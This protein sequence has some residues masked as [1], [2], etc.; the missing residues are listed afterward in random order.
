MTIGQDIIKTLWGSDTADFRLRNQFVGGVLD[1][2]KLSACAFVK[3]DAKGECTKWERYWNRRK[4]KVVVVLGA[5]G[6]LYHLALLKYLDL[7]V[8][9]YIGAA[10]VQGWYYTSE[11]ATKTE[12][13]IQAELESCLRVPVVKDAATAFAATI[14]NLGF[15]NIE[16]TAEEDDAFLLCCLTNHFREKQPALARFPCGILVRHSADI[17]N[18]RPLKDMPLHCGRLGLLP[19]CARMIKQLLEREKE[20]PANIWCNVGSVLSDNLRNPQ[21]ALLCFYEAIRIDPRLLQP[22]KN[23][24]ITGKR[25][26]HKCF[27]NRDFATAASCA[28]EVVSVGDLTTKDHGFFSYRGLALEKLNRPEDARKAY[29]AALK[30]DPDCAISQRGL[31]R[32]KAGND[33]HGAAQQIQLLIESGAYLDYAPESDYPWN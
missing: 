22:R 1:V 27:V 17:K 30:I 33:L 32:L 21:A 14:R 13:A 29:E 18:P 5:D 2:A 3:T 4:N 20:L 12:N 25:L 24:W 9:D 26:M 23:V 16:R 11:C 31:Q 28:D 6:T 10:Y 15:A 7:Q 19:E 8:D